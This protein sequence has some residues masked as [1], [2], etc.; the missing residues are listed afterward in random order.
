[1]NDLEL[2]IEYFEGVKTP[3]IENLFQTKLYNDAAFKA[4]VED[5]KSIVLS[6]KTDEVIKE[7]VKLFKATLHEVEKESNW[8]EK[9]KPKLRHLPF[10]F[11]TATAAC[12]LIAFFWISIKTSLDY[13]D[14]RN[15][16]D[17]NLQ[18][19]SIASDSN[20]VIASHSFN[21]ADYLRAKDAL[22]SSLSVYPNDLELRFYLGLCYLELNDL[23]KAKDIFQSTDL[24]SSVF[25]DDCLWYLSLCYLR[26]KEYGL[27]LNSLN[28]IDKT[29][30]NYSDVKRLKRSIELSR[31][32]FWE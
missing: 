17:L 24:T 4:L 21:I 25:K 23:D 19:K 1:M 15:H 9:K 7:D 31:F 29:Y 20:L 26:E 22:Q 12:L 5:Y 3:E 16:T 32:K 10:I 18:T 14:Y 27:C 6:A 8:V 28:M 2:I 11:S 30:H 13:S